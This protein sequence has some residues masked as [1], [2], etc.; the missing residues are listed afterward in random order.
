[1][2]YITR[3]NLRTAVALQAHK[4]L[5][6]SEDQ[7]EVDTW[8]RLALA[9]LVWAG[10]WWWLMAHK[11]LALVADQINYD[12]PAGFMRIQGDSLFYGDT[13][14]VRLERG[15]E[16]IDRKL[17][18]SWKRSSGQA[19]TPLYA[20]LMGA[21]DTTETSAELWLAPKPSAAFVAANAILDYYWYRSMDPVRV[22]GGALADDDILLVPGWMEPFAVRA[23]MVFSLQEQDDA[24]FQTALREFE[25][26]DVPRMRMF[27]P[28][29]RSTEPLQRPVLPRLGRRRTR[30]GYG[31]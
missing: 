26:N 1:M 21:A 20:T 13:G 24:A 30:Y 19:G 22:A 11:E 10:D 23:S 12:L 16:I 6:T 14:V 28:D 25:D 15:P 2:D 8:I 31:R 18:P 7:G 4:D 27:D 5:G 3:V 17:G 9:R 29:V